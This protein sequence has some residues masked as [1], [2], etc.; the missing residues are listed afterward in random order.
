MGKRKPQLMSFATV[1][2]TS[3]GLLLILYLHILHDRPPVGKTSYDHT[4]NLPYLIN[5]EAEAQTVD[6]SLGIRSKEVPE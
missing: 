3:H 1:P 5:M 4:C 2:G 6:D